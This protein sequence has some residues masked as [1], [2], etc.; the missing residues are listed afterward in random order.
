[1]FLR[2][3]ISMTVTAGVIAAL[4]WNP[5]QADTSTVSSA[6]V[7]NSR[8]TATAH[9]KATAIPKRAAVYTD[10]LA[11]AMN[12]IRRNHDLRPLK[13]RPCLDR[14]A[15]RWARHL[16]RTGKFEHQSL[17]PLLNQCSLSRVGEILAKGNVRPRYMIKMW[18]DSPGHRALLL[19]PRFR[20]A[21]VS[22]RRGADGAWVGCID[23][24]RG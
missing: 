23:F 13:V 10:R 11:D 19:D 18:L 5:G 20:K 1:M 15:L 21:G 4:G 8:P 9:E 6:G 17:T 24:G 12:D 7:I 22:A 2:T 3:L 14:F 16:A